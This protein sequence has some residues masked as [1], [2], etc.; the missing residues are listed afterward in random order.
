MS[1]ETTPIQPL[2]DAAL[3][4]EC[5]EDIEPGILKQARRATNSGEKVRKLAGMLVVFLHQARTFR[6]KGNIKQ[7][8]HY[9]D[10][11]D[12]VYNELPLV[13]RY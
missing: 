4:L 7:A 12:T 11:A 10:M 3:A 6:L 13:W 1:T 2:L 5:N 9:E 8:T